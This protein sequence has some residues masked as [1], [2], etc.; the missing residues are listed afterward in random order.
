MKSK[1]HPAIASLSLGRAYAGHLLSDKIAA[2]AAVGF[3]GIECF[4]EDLEYHTKTFSPNDDGLVHDKSPNDRDLCAAAHDFRLLAD[5]HNLKVIVL[6]P[7]M[8]YEGL[9]D[10]AQ[11]Q[12]RLEKLDLWMKLASIIGT[13]LIQVPSNFLLKGV[14]GDIG[15]LVEDLQ[16]LADK[17]AEHDPPVRFAYE[18]V[19]WGTFI[20]TWRKA[21]DVVKV[22]DRKNFGLCL[23]A[24][25]IAGREWAD[26]TTESGVVGSGVENAT[27]LLHK[28]LKD[29]A[30]TVDVSKVYYVQFADARKP[31]TPIIPVRGQTARM[32]WSRQMRVFAGESDGYMPVDIV[33]ESILAA[34]PVGLGY[35]GWLSVELFNTSLEGGDGQI[36]P[37]H[38]ARAWRSWLSVPP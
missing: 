36:V 27:E 31:K 24:F 33:L 38:A 22:V 14:T 7:F 6:Q 19:C 21:W 37:E 9:T 3:Q 25:H 34:P 26:P 11:R 2:A 29:M 8:H 18:G 20:D 16:L 4:Y 5:K 23:D 35:T 15:R 13:D 1:V 32:T 10:P 30:A 17:G 28:S 12:Q